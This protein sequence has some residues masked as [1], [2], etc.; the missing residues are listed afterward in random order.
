MWLMQG[1]KGSPRGDSVCVADDDCNI[2]SLM[3]TDS[4]CMNQSFP[5]ARNCSLNR[6]DA[7]SSSSS[8]SGGPG[9][10]RFHTCATMRGHWSDT[11][12]YMII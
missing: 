8:S 9:P 4:F 11:K 10:D 2:N 5:S 3:K 7:S 1:R 6:V 12:Y